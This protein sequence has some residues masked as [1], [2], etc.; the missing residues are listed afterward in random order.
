YEQKENKPSIVMHPL[1][2]SQRFKETDQI[3]LKFPKEKIDKVFNV[4]KSKEPFWLSDK[5]VFLGEID[6][7]FSYEGNYTIGKIVVDGQEKD[8]YMIDDTALACITSEG[9]VIIAGCSHSGICN[10][11]EQAKR[12]CNCDEVRAVIG[13]FHLKEGQEEQIRETIEYFK[14]SPQSY[15]YSCHCTDQYSKFKLKN[16]LS[17][18]YDISVGS[19]L[20]FTS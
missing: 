17:N 20:E 15:L 4:K 5:V 12:V 8:D 18:F 2:L 3:G 11:V 7:S 6:R 16:H 19:K 10:I 1:A 13:G 9:L 14:K